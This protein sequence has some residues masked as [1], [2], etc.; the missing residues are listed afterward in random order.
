VVLFVLCCCVCDLFLFYTWLVLF[1]PGWSYSQ[2]KALNAVQSTARG[3]E[4]TRN[5]NR[6]VEIWNLVH[7]IHKNELEQSAAAREGY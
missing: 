4:Y 5:R 2:V 3:E 1:T 6:V 7:V